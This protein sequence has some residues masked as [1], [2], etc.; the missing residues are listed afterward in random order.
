MPDQSTR[1]Y[2]VSQDAV[3]RGFL[4]GGIGMVAVILALLILITSRPQGQL[5]ALDNG[6][7]QALL[8]EAEARLTGFELLD[9]GAARIDIEHAM[10][11]VVER[12]VELSFAAPAAVADAPGAMVAEIDGAAVYTAQCAACHQAGGGGI[13]GAFPPLAGHVGDL[14]AADPEYLIDVMLYGLQGQITVAGAS[15]NGLM[16]AFGQLGDPE[17]AAVLNHVLTAWGDADELGDAF[18]PYAPDD[19]DARRGQG[20]TAS[21]V[22]QARGALDLD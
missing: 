5:Q 1:Q 20:L 7:H 12:G 21:D 16:P 4:L 8:A 18:A 14:Y 6:Q 22:L 2:I 10:R 15:Y 11:L 3:R 13:P 9:D 19:V 17:I